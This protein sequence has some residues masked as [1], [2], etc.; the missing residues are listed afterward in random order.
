VPAVGPAWDRRETAR[1]PGTLYVSNSELPNSQG[2]AGAL[3]FDAAGALVDAYPILH[4]A[5]INCGGG[6]TPW[7]TWLSGEEFPLG[8]V[9]EC[10][11]PAGIPASPVRRWACSRTKRSRS[12]HSSDACT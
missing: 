4:G 11:P 8:R 6:A 10:D 7:G 9:R 3:C 2:G 1:T 5:S 12:T